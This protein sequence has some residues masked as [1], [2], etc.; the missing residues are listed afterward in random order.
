MRQNLGMCDYDWRP[1]FDNI[2]TI[3]KRS[4]NIEPKF[5]YVR[6]CNPELINTCVHTCQPYRDSLYSTRILMIFAVLYRRTGIF[7]W[8]QVIDCESNNN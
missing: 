6:E 2:V 3:K 7:N 4:L 5:K 1:K 8:D